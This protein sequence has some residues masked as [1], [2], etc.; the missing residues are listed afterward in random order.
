[1]ELIG[2]LL[3]FFSA[4]LETIDKVHGSCQWCPSGPSRMMAILLR[5]TTVFP[6][7]QVQYE[8][9]VDWLD[10]GVV[11]VPWMTVLWMT[12]CI[13][14]LLLNDYRLCSDLSIFLDG[15]SHLNLIV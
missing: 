15:T 14:V 11:C 10:Q 7:C 13:N 4:Q 12:R 2:I 3:T 8:D 9:F 6:L 1:M 5:R